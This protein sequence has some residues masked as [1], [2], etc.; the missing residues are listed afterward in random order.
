MPQPGEI[1][2]N[3]RVLR[4]IGIGGF[5]EVYEAEDT[6]L[7]RK[8]ALKV[9]PPELA[10]K[11][12]LVARFE[13][14]VHT[15]AALDHPGIVPIYTVGHVG[16]VH[17]YAMRL[18]PGGDLR[19]RMARGIAPDQALGWLSELAA[20]FGHAHAKGVIHRDVKPENILFDDKGH[21]V[22]TDF[23]VAKI[24]RSENRLTATGT[25]IGTPQYL[26]PEQA[27]GADVDGRS[28]LYGLGIILFELLAGHAPYDGADPL[29]VVL[30]HVTEPI[31]QLP[32]EH[33]S[34]Q[35]LIERLLAK[36]PAQR[37]GSAEEL[38][39]ELLR[40]LRELRPQAPRQPASGAAAAPARSRPADPEMPPRPAA[41]AAA[42][43]PPRSV[44]ADVTRSEARPKP[45][46][47][48]RWRLAGAL[49][50][51]FAFLLGVWS[52]RQHGTPLQVPPPAGDEA[53]SADSASATTA[54][55]AANPTPAGDRTAR[56]AREKKRCALH[57]SA[58]TPEGD[59]VYDDAQRF[60]GARPAANGSGIR[61]PG[62]KLPNGQI[63]NALVTPQGCVLILGMMAG[64][65]PGT[66]E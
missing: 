44:A 62:A 43:E 64:P 54:V 20:A 21:A 16:D 31:P 50:L 4:L 27:R 13:R 17:Y 39:T 38:R 26:S 7:Q 53:V 40:S 10:R 45:R 30:M 6:L 63:V 37:L 12:D 3:Y 33:R 60:P 56:I 46:R 57:I 49:A 65:A 61:I 11:P 28:D 34:L 51:L 24:L 22:L 19:Q 48:A 23:G 32:A 29:S 8:V 18:L 55:V 1:L 14:E 42:A 52:M 47:L 36:H 9:L 25:A 66:T 41:A 35:P 15:V 58:L 5:A 2:G 59:L